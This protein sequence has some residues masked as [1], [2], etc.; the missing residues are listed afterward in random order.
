[1]KDINKLKN[2]RLKYKRYYNIDFDNTYEIHHIDFNRNNNNIENLL[3]LPKKLHTKYHFYLQ[4]LDLLNWK[5]GKIELNIKINQ[6][7]L[8]PY[9]NDNEI[10]KFLEVYNECIKWLNYKERLEFNKRNRSNI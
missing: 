7:G 8:L 4:E 9:T 2:Y 10:I 6:F 1:M 3:L 5:T